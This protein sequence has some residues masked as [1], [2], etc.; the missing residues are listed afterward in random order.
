MT[1]T[2]EL[3]EK[4]RTDIKEAYSWYEE[5]YAGLGDEFMLSLDSSLSLLQRN[6]FMFQKRMEHMRF[7]L[8]RR[9]PYLV[10]YVANEHNLAITVLGVI[11][12]HRNP[13]FISKRLRS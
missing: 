11:S 8:L 3:T 4:S 5:Q 12:T 7:A 2:I 13:E 6:P 9:F 10:A 1:F